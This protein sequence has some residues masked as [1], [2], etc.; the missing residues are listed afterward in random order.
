MPALPPLPKRLPL[1]TLSEAGHFRIARTAHADREPSFR[2]ARIYRFDAPDG[3]FGTLYCARNFKTCFLE[4][5]VRDRPDLTLSSADFHA[6][7]VL[8]LLL[9]TEKLRLVPLYGDAATRMRLDAADLMGKD[10]R[11]TQAL[12][13]LIHDHADAPDGIVYRSRFDSGTTAVVLF[14]RA[15]PRV[16]LFPGSGPVKFGDAEELTAA[17]RSTVPY[18]LV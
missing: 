11:Y 2:N 16:R 13:K 3:E 18:C 5:V 15:A 17:V 1:E 8:F 9:D 10:Y 6:R 7:S 12:A 4:T 14:D